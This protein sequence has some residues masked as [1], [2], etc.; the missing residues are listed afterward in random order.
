[1]NVQ[2]NDFFFSDFIL[3]KLNATRLPLLVFY[4]RRRANITWSASRPTR[5]SPRSPPSWRRRT[6]R[7]AQ[8]NL[9]ENSWTA[10]GGVGR[11]GSVLH[12]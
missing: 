11:W 4:R 9:R 7:W 1:V 6:C 3:E 2:C 12:S 10:I 5:S 8:L